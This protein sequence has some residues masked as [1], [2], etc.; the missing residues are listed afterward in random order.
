MNAPT[1]AKPQSVPKDN[2][3]DRIV[4]YGFLGLLGL[5]AIHQ[6][7]TTFN[8]SEPIPHAASPAGVRGNLSG[9][10][11]P[12]RPGVAATGSRGSTG[13]PGPHRAEAARHRA[14]TMRGRIDAQEQQWRRDHERWRNR[15]SENPY[16]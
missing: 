11:D 9:P 7:N 5:Y 10:S 4:M 3:L 2:L 16:Q 12:P 13:K 15:A 6:I 1:K 8:G 14:E